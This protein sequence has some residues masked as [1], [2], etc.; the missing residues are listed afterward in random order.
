MP[1][2]RD[3]F[4]ETS[5]QLREEREQWL[6]LHGTSPEEL[7][8]SSLADLKLERPFLAP[9]RK[10]AGGLAQAFAFFT[11]L[12]RP[13]KGADMV[14]LMQHLSAVLTFRKSV[15]RHRPTCLPA[16]SA[17]TLEAMRYVAGV[18]RFIFSEIGGPRSHM[19]PAAV[20][21]F[22]SG[23][24]TLTRCQREKAA[25]R[26]G[27]P[28]DDFDFHGPEGAIFFL[29]FEF[30]LLAALDVLSHPEFHAEEPVWS[31]ED[32]RCL[33]AALLRAEHIY[34]R[35]YAS[36]DDC[37]LPIATWG[38]AS[39]RRDEYVT[40][41]PEV[42]SGVQ[43]ATLSLSDLCEQATRCIGI[44]MPS[45]IAAPPRDVVFGF[46]NDLFCE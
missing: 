31:S 33:A 40:I 25:E 43:F 38:Y 29:W 9:I 13:I 7:F 17:S 10:S 12:N 39:Y 32:W 30:A 18:Q 3:F 24:L 45:D 42:V 34:L 35:T 14:A 23:S 20:E 21:A 8:E 4:L 41:E 11:Q 15:L 22:A 19:V 46:G 2:P 37:G 44:A 27:R 36:L 6:L 5:Q 1:N 28:H 16:A 26:I